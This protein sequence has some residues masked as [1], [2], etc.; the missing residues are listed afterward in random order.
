M[1]TT[2]QVKAKV[3]FGGSIKSYVIKVFLNR[4]YKGTNFCDNP[5]LGCSRNYYGDDR[6]A[7]TEFLAEHGM[8]LVSMVKV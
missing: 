5:E 8:R 3:D 2:Y 4:A 7:I 1:G 6:Y